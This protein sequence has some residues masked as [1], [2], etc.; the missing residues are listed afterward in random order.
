MKRIVAIA[1]AAALLPAA[2]DSPI[3]WQGWS[4]DLFTRAERERKLVLL[5]L[6][7]VW[8]HW[9]HVM[10]ETTYKDPQVAAIV[11]RGYI[12]VKVDQD[13]RPDLSNRYEDYGWPATILFSP[14]GK[15]LA[16]LSGYV[17]P[18]RMRALLQEFLDDPRPGPSVVER[19]IMRYAAS[20]ALPKSLIDELKTIHV[21]NYDPNYGSWGTVHKFLPSDPVEYAME[22]AAAGD[23]RN[24][25]MA[26]QTLDAQLALIDPVWGGVYQYSHG[27]VWT[28]PHFEKIVW[29]QAANLRIYS[30]AYAMFG[31]AKYRKAAESVHRYLRDFLT[32]PQGAFYTSQDADVKQGEHSEAYFQLDDAGRRRVGMPRIDQ[33]VYSRENGWMIEA[34]AALATVSGNRGALEDAVRAAEWILARRALPSGGFRH[35]ERDAA[36]PY[37]GDT[38]AMGRAFLQLYATTADRAW[39]AR[40]EAAARFIAANF[41]SGKASEPCFLTAK[42]PA[43]GLPPLPQR[44]ENIQVA[45]FA[46]L[47]SHYTGKMD[48]K[49]LAQSAMQYLATR[50]IATRRPTAGVLLADR[51][52]HSDPTHITVVGAKSDPAAQKLYEAAR[53]HPSGYLRVEWLDPKEGPLPNPDVQY[54]VLER[55]AAFSCAAGRCSRPVFEPARI[56]EVVGRFRAARSPM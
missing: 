5:D 24:R 18:Q 15:E 44:D 49:K 55:P 30:M 53:R 25:K 50:E 51:E 13:S 34:L 42:A 10:D 4:D 37:L 3:R 6:E 40:A 28:N 19:P 52:I 21:A 31:D 54:P 47:L 12:A 43:A 2:S 22:L 32:S 7:A 29:V 33:H 17:P 11:A 1:L 23:P 39:L 56:A 9:C 38:L 36:G 41:R 27:G 16:K 48:Y 46:N 20:G 8:C 26:L 35:D 45:R 14:Q